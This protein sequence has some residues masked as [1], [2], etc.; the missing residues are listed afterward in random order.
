MDFRMLLIFFTHGASYMIAWGSYLLLIGGA[1]YCE[2]CDE[3]PDTRLTRAKYYYLSAAALFFCLTLYCIAG[4]LSYRLR[5]GG[6]PWGFITIRWLLLDASAAL[7]L[8][9]Y[10]LPHEQGHSSSIRPI[11]HVVS[12]YC[13]SMWVLLMIPYPCRCSRERHT[14]ASGATL[15]LVAHEL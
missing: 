13:A 3:N 6:M 9:T 7:A 15:H 11:A 2:G 1:F 12:A 4:W 8:L 10:L 5:S 14:R